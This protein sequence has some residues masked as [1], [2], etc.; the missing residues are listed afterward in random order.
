METIRTIV[1]HAQEITKDKQRFIACSAEINKK[2]YKI[3]FTKDVTDA[4]KTKGLY[5]LTID[6]DDCSIE[7]G[8][9]YTNK[10][11]KKGVENDTIWVRHIVGMRMYTEDDLKAANRI[12]M[13]EVFGG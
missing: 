6:F 13:N 11:G 4:P 9:Q 8:K 10:Q 7:K 5:D 3:K 2:W 1:L 12:A